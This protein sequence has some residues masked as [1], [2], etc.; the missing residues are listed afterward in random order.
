M[1]ARRLEAAVVVFIVA[2]VAVCV[3]VL[4]LVPAPR[5][6]PAPGPSC[7]VVVYEDGSG[8]RY[9]GDRESGTWP[10]GSFEWGGGGE[11]Q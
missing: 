3:A 1:T 5:A 11:N 10:A 8:V 6:L 4:V 2:A 7:D 9:C